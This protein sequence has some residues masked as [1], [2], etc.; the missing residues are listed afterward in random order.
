MSEGSSLT[1]SAR[2]MLDPS[3]VRSELLIEHANR[4]RKSGQTNPGR[5]SSSI[6][7]LWKSG[8]G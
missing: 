7:G 4:R 3:S 8:K 2:K 5:A 6:G 1:A